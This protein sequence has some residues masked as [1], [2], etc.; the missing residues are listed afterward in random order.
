M[1]EICI[2]GGQ[3]VL[4]HIALLE[5]PFKQ[6]SVF[7][8]ENFHQD[9]TRPYLGGCTCNIAAVMY[10]L[11][12]D[13]HLSCL[14]GNWQKDADVD[15]LLR[16]R[17]PSLGRLVVH[18]QKEMCHCYQI[19]DSNQD[20]FSVMTGILE[21]ETEDP[22]CIN[23]GKSP[24]ICLALPENN[25]QTASLIR[26]VRRT[27][28]CGYPVALSMISSPGHYPEELISSA[29]YIFLNTFERDL[30]CKQY[31]KH[32]QAISFLLELGVRAVFMT[33]GKSGS[34]IFEKNTPDGVWVPAAKPKQVCD[35]TGAGDGYAAG[36]MAGI[37][38][39]YSYAAAACIGSVV[40]SYIVEQP[41]AQENCPTWEM[42]QTRRK[43]QFSNMGENY[44]ENYGM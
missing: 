18:S 2:A 29:D 34:R 36:T 13:V 30:L 35:T 43:E 38:K 14:T 3:I 42:V 19:Y 24:L 20:K 32:T 10:R 15:R 39:G 44:G 31:G 27:K 33:M 8:Q 21:P 40:S 1:N 25:L 17:I 41:G 9:I 12:F 6:N 37:L 22:Y 23:D 16:S 7:L 4:D 5:E 28:A 11:G 26:L